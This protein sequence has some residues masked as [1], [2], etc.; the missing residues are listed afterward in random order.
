MPDDPDTAGDEQQTPPHRRRTVVLHV[1][2]RTLSLTLLVLVLAVATVALVIPKVSGAIPL[3]VLSSSMDPTMPVGSL[4]VV[5]PTMDTLTGTAETLRPDEIDAVNH[6]DDIGVGDVIVF[7]PSAGQDML[8]IHRVIGVNVSSTG[9][10]IFTT[11]GDNNSGVDDPVAS[12]Q[13]R[14][15]L[16]YHVPLLGYVN[17]ALDNDAKQWI[18]VG[19]AA[20]GYSWA[21]VL[22]ARSASRRR[23]DDPGPD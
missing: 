12:H 16:W 5:R 15:V 7:A 21:L 22:F 8:I 17:D 9:Q 19:V 6:V 10:R 13:V 1:L 20:V 18:A 23:T 11:Q 14:A 2:G 3:S 4:A